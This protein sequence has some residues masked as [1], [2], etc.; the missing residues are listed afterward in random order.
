KNSLIN[1]QTKLLCQGELKNTRGQKLHVFLFEEI[2]LF[3]RIATRNDVKCYQL[4]N[5]PIPIEL[6][7]IEDL[8]DG[9]KIQELNTGSFSRTL[10]GTKQAR[11]VFRCSTIENNSSDGRITSITLQARDVYDKQQWIQ[12]FK[13]VKNIVEI[14]KNS[15]LK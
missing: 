6:L 1:K 10:S 4:T 2:L 9:C 11:N 12:A 15:I 3:T 14:T 8:E 13:N 5:Y 7:L